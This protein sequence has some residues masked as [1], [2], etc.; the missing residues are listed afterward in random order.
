[1]AVQ[2]KSKNAIYVYGFIPAGEAKE[3]SFDIEGIDGNE[4]FLLSCGDISAVASYVERDAFSEERLE[5]LFQ[6]PQWLQEKANHH[7]KT[8]LELYGKFTVLP[9]K[10]CTI[11]HDVK[12]I[13]A[14]VSSKDDQLKILFGLL[15]NKEEWSVKIYSQKDLLRQH[16]LAENSRVHSLHEEM[17]KASPG[18][19]F[20]LKKRI[21]QEIEK[22]A[23]KET[24]LIIGKLYRKLTL[25]SVRDLKKNLWSRQVTGREEE[26]AFNY[27][28]LLEKEK[29]KDFKDEVIKFQREFGNIGIKAELTGPWPPY[30]FLGEKG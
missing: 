17:D 4:L 2:P 30:D 3:T 23:L 24:E 6:D 15:E 21:E 9:L 18:K 27:S 14:E 22:E 26:M 28:F 19:K 16:L 8:L 10:F 12:G 13:E 1:M 5:H 11:F 20:F 29:I 25:L 7:H